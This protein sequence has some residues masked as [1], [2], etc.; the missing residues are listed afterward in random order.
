MNDHALQVRV[1]AS[2]QHDVV[3][4]WQLAG[5][6]A[7]QLREALRGLRRVHRGVCALGDL[8]EL[9]WYMA[10]ALSMGPTGR[11][12][13]LSALQLME[14]RPVKPGD[15]HVTHGGGG[16]S[17][18]DGLALH[19]CAH[20]ERW[21]YKNVPTVSPTRA[22]IE[23]NLKPHELYRALDIAERRGISVDHRALPSKDV[24]RLHGTTRGLTKSEA[25]ALFVWRCHEWGL[26]LP[27]VN[28]Y[29]NGFETD[30]HWPDLRLVVEVDG[31]EHHKEKPQFTTD[32]YRGLIH[33]A[34]GYEVVR[35]SADHVYDEP[36]LVRGALTGVA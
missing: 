23:S 25:E 15:I 34:N 5:L 27:L 24:V 12:S 2:T 3:A 35:I 29:L 16:R 10:A 11:I 22:L 14:L 13:H 31:W 20:D 17:R 9:G 18:R 33:R 26:P 30:F 36:D 6:S 7:N 19:R 8:T 28:Q 1:L 32:R 21:S 4:T